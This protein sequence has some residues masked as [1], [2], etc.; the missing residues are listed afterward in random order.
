MVI[1]FVKLVNLYYFKKYF[2]FFIF[3]FE[4]F[5]IR[6]L[7]CLDSIC[8]CMFLVFEIFESFVSLYIEIL[9]YL[10]ILVISFIYGSV[11]FNYYI[12]M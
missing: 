3:F 7:C 9:I 5:I 11:F 12:M 1:L 8:I 4:C 2:T 6:I 10:K